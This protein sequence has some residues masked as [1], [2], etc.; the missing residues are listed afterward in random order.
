MEDTTPVKTA[1]PNWELQHRI[2]CVKWY[3]KCGSFKKIK[4][5]FRAFFGL[6]KAPEKP[7]IQRWVKKFET[8]GTVGNINSKSVNRTSHSGR[9]KCRTQEVIDKVRD[10]S[11]LRSTDHRSPLRRSAMLRCLKTTGRS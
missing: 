4:E 7:I 5:Q 6:D 10:H 2:F 1:M 3:F 11:S 8:L 9:P